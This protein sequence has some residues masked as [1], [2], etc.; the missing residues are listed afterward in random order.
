MREGIVLLHILFF[1]FLIHIYT[2]T[3]CKDNVSTIDYVETFAPASR[4]I[5]YVWIINIYPKLVLGYS[6][7][8]LVGDPNS[9]ATSKHP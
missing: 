4:P 2:F 6:H 1:F 7:L 8:V 5:A 3:T 9:V